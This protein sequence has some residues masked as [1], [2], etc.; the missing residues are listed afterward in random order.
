MPKTELQ[1]IVDQLAALNRILKECKRL[2][3]K[4]KQ[5]IPYKLG[6]RIFI[7]EALIN[8]VKTAPEVIS[9]FL[10]RLRKLDKL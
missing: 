6:P 2:N 7:P 3:I 5:N 8:E 9:G 10:R 4:H 1:Q